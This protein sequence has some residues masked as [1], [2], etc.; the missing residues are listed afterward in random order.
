MEDAEI[1]RIEAALTEVLADFGLAD[2]VQPVMDLLDEHEA[3][4]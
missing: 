1:I 3:F 4:D 2:Y